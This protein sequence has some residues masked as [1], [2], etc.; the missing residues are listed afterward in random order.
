MPLFLFCIMNVG[1][2]NFANKKNDTKSVPTLSR[3]GLI[4]RSL[5]ENISLFHELDNYC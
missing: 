5:L 1:C 2:A 4:L 3:R